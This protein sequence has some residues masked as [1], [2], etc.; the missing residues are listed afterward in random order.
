MYKTII[1]QNGKYII[2]T[3]DINES[4]EVFI[5]RGYYVI[6]LLNSNINMDVDKAIQQSR[7]WANNKFLFCVY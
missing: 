2:L 6:S 3:S 7:L 4:R 5:E 1:I